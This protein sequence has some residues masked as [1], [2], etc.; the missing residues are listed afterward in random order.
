[1]SILLL[2]Q[3]QNWVKWKRADKQFSGEICCE[4]SR[5]L[6][7]WLY[8]CRCCCRN[9]W[10]AYNLCNNKFSSLLLLFFFAHFNIS[11]LSISS[12]VFRILCVWK[13][14]WCWHFPFAIFGEHECHQP[15]QQ[16]HRQQH[17]SRK[18]NTYIRKG[19]STAKKKKKRKTRWE[20]KKS[21]AKEN[22]K[23]Q[24]AWKRWREKSEKTVRQ[25]QQ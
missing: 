6:H 16:R 23:N 15:H 24:T 4:S 14:E 10:I 13:C 11:A 3:N 22:G 8:L 18:R 5:C 19:T 1:M 21:S 12:F 17:Q 20:K 9:V 2:L 7:L 25:P